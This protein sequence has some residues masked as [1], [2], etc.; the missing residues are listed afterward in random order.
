MLISEV[1]AVIV[2]QGND[3]VEELRPKTGAPVFLGYSMPKS[4]KKNLSRILNLALKHDSHSNVHHYVRTYNG[5][6]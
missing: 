1:L 4:E 3:R 6:T 2:C 5:Q